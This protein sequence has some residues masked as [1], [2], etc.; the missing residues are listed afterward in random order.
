MAT[1]THHFFHNFFPL[2]LHVLALTGH[3]QVNLVC[4]TSYCNI[5]ANIYFNFYFQLGNLLNLLKLL[6]SS[7][8]WYFTVSVMHHEVL[9]YLSL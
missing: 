5:H 8:V 3:H 6:K 1:F 2:Q 4:Y 7:S 9:N